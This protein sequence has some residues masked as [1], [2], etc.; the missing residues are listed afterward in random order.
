MALWHYTKGALQ[1][2]NSRRS[3]EPEVME[4]NRASNTVDTSQL[5]SEANLPCYMLYLAGLLGEG[6]SLCPDMSGRLRKLIS[7]ASKGIIDVECTSWQ[8]EK[9][10]E[11]W[12]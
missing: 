6:W 2:V 3:E 9:L 1:V 5:N 12:S 10:G 11:R 7:K 8:P 4:R